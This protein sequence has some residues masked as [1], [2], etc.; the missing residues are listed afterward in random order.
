[1]ENDGITEGSI[2]KHEKRHIIFLS[3]TN[4]YAGK[5]WLINYVLSDTKKSNCIHY[6]TDTPLPITGLI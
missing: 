4:V 2:I 3:L 6:D 1:M 5:I